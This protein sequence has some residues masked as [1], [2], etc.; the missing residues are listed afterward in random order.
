MSSKSFSEKHEPGAVLSPLI[1]H[2]I[3][4]HLQNGE[5]WCASAFK[6]AKALDVSADQV[7][8]TAD[9]MNV[10]LARC[11]LGIFGFGPRK[12]IVQPVDSP[13][14]GL[15]DA[16]RAALIEQRLPCRAAWDIARKFKV[17]K[18]TVSGVCETI[19]IKIRP[20]QL[21]AF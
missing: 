14:E 7:G 21:G 10:R 17:A 19:G 2:Q 16:I 8:K 5:L 20:C 12:K 1:R 6:I 4:N 13:I 15:E 11:Q 3:E 9:L 18:M